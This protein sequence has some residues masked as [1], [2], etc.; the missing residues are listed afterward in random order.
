MPV[1]NLKLLIPMGVYRWH[2]HHFSRL[3][4]MVVGCDVSNSFLAVGSGEVVC[5][6]GVS[7]PLWIFFLCKKTPVG[8]EPT[9]TSV[10]FHSVLLWQCFSGV[11]RLSA[12]QSFDSS[13]AQLPGARLSHYMGL[14]LKNF[15]CPLVIWLTHN[16]FFE[17]KGH[18]QIYFLFNFYFILESSW[19]TM[20]C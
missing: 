11:S 4:F 15:Q 9:G 20:S 18:S 8:A 1:H 16:T 14:Y 7:G 19:F 13:C 12:Y 17:I 10:P 3:F 2:H 6:R 5:C